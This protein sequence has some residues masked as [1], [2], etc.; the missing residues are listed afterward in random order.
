LSRPT[1]VDGPIPFQSYS[2]YCMV[3][4]SG[5]STKVAYMTM[6]GAANSQPSQVLRGRRARRA[7]RPVVG[8]DIN[9]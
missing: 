8:T 2:E 9:S 6:A 1:Q 4:A 5:R 7:R 3:N